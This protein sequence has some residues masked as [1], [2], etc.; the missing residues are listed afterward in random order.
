MKNKAF[1]LLGMLFLGLLSNIPTAMAHCPLCTGAAVGGVE[2]A[3]YFGVDD[4]ISGLL[5]GATIVSS[6]LWFNKWLKKKVNFRF[7]EAVIVGASFFLFA[8][9]FYYTGLITNFEMVRSM[10]THH[11]FA[12]LGPLGIDKLLFGMILGML[13]IWLTFTISDYLTERKGKVLWPY[14]SL[15][16]MVGVLGALSLI[17]WLST[18]AAGIS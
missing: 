15:S 9:P 5:L 3:R 4:S 17:L 10:P 16:L 1:A 12:W 14:Q 6:A 11:S 7:Q 8:V 18:K 2:L 13:L